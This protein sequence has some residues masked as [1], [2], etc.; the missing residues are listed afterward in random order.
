MNSWTGD[1]ACREHPADW[2]H[3]DDGDD[4]RRALA[5]C[6]RCPVQAECLRFILDTEPADTRTGIWGAT[7]P[8]QRDR[9]AR[10]GM[11]RRPA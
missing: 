9:I 8:A 10:A 11:L 3:P 7:T 1:A 6:R 5:V 4:K 2:W